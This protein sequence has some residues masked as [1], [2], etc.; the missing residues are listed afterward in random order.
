[1]SE[2]RFIQLVQ[3]NDEYLLVCCS[4]EGKSLC[5]G[6]HNGGVWEDTSTGF[7]LR[8]VYIGNDVELP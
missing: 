1:M 3:D 8:Y 4:Q 6:K 5:I 7:H 2:D